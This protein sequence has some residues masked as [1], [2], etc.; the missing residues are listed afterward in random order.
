MP[1][2]MRSGRRLGWSCRR[3]EPACP[4]LGRAPQ[5]RALIATGA[6][7][8]PSRSARPSA[9]PPQKEPQGD[10]LHGRVS[11]AAAPEPWPRRSLPIQ[12]TLGRL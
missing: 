3:A 12:Q 1:R 11:A 2:R 7:E 10:S 5:G 9:P 8:A 6:G 4:R